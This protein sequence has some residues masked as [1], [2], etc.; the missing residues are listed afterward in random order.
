L[1]LKALLSTTDLAALRPCLGTVGFELMPI[2]RE[3][4]KNFHLGLPIEEMNKRLSDQAR[5]ERMVI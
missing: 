5:A 4:D 1:Q 2:L 3:L